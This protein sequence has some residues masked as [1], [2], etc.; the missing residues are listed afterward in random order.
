MS[1]GKNFL[2]VIIILIVG[3]GLIYYFGFRQ[4]PA[5]EN[6]QTQQTNSPREIQSPAPGLKIEILQEGTGAQVQNN[7]TA[8]VN[9][10][11]KLENGTVFDSSLNPGR[12]PFSFTLGAGGVIK[13]WELGI[14]GMKVGEK[15]RLTIAPELAYGE[16]GA[17][18]GVIPPKATLI[19]EV[20]LLEIK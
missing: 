5:P 11:G 18:N 12:T 3:G 13:G 10:T 4:K 8:V 17:G 6:M 2:V 15:R 20:E 9:Y 7:Q 1:T 19:F 14:L 16:A